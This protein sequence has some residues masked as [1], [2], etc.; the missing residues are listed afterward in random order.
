[1]Y[2]YAGSVFKGG[3]VECPAEWTQPQLAAEFNALRSLRS[4][5]YRSLTTA[6][7]AGSIGSFLEAQVR[8]TT[9]SEQLY[10]LLNRFNENSRWEGER[11]DYS[12]SDVL[13][14]P[15]T[16]VAFEGDSGVSCVGVG[17]LG[18]GVRVYSEEGE[19]EW[20]GEGCPV[21]VCVWRAEEAGKHKCP[22]C[23]LW[24]SDSKNKLCTRCKQVES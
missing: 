3:W 11:R 2:M 1:M 17:E 5:V 23:W 8:V 14:V 24:V 7:E 18:E 13:I 9:P 16:F 22:R 20:A 21:R 4:L 15:R 10:A 12:L 19:V 6:R